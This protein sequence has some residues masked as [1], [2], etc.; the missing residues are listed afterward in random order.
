ME[1]EEKL[2][3]YLSDNV[4]LFDCQDDCP[5]EE[6]QRMVKPDEYCNKCFAKLI[7]TLV[8]E[9]GYVKLADM[10][11]RYLPVKETYC[12]DNGWRKVESK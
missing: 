8:K 4:A 6:A 10:D 9:A 7:I 1:L 5:D 3:K 11:Y 12:Y 2:T